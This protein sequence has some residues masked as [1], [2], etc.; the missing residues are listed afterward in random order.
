MKLPEFI[1]NVKVTTLNSIKVRDDCMNCVR[2]FK[3]NFNDTE[4][5]INSNKKFLGTI[6]KWIDEDDIVPKD[7]KTSDNVVLHPLTNIPII[8]VEL[9]FSSEIYS[10]VLPGIYREYNYNDELEAFMSTNNIII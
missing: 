4:Y 5:L 6:N 3:L 2:L 9:N 7:Y 8:E 1:K 10:G